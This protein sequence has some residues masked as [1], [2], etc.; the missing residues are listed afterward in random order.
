MGDDYKDYPFDRDDDAYETITAIRNEQK[1]GGYRPQWI[2]DI[3]GNRSVLCCALDV[4]MTT[5]GSYERSRKD[6]LEDVK[7]LMYV[8]QH[9]KASLQ[10]TYVFDEAVKKVIQAAINEFAISEVVNMTR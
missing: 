3:L 1:T 6:Q 9:W 7:V 2:V 4:H 10:F 8:I 5:T